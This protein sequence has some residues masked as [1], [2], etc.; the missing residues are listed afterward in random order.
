MLVAL[1]RGRVE[2]LDDLIRLCE[3]MVRRHAERHA[4]RRAD[5]DDIVQ[6]VWVRLMLKCGQIRDPMTLIAW[7]RIVTQRLAAQLGHRDARM[8]PTPLPH[9]RP[10]TSNTEA[11]ALARHRRDEA[12][13]GVRIAL[14]RLRARDQELLLLLHRD[15]RPGYDEISRAVGRPVGS[16]GPS[17]R[18]L[19]ERLRRDAHVARL[20][21]LP[22]AS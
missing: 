20:A 18:R 1:Q 19:L 6:E 13:R 17:R 5:V 21:D 12:V 10:C 3:P 2:A 8:E 22:A 16:L 7:L 15:D 11:D 4:W 9:D 14:R